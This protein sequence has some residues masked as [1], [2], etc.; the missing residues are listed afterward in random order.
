MKN[1]A[2]LGMAIKAEWLKIKGLGL[3]TLA[4]VFALIIPTL[5]FTIDVFREDSRIYDG[6]LQKASTLAVKDT[7]AQFGAFFMLLLI[8]IAATRI[9]QID[10]KNNHT[11]YHE[12]RV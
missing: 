9:T 6:L 2:T 8:I 10:H 7:I 3:L 4:I 11:L 1:K 5:I 12:H